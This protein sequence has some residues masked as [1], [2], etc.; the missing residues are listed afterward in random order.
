MD[1]S[2]DDLLEYWEDDVNT[3]VIV[4]YQESFGDPRKFGRIARRVSHK[5]PVIAVKAGRSAVGAKAA[6]SH[7]G[8]L[9]ASDVAVDALFRH[10]GVIRVTTIEEMFNAAEVLTHQPLPKSANEAILTTPEAWCACGH[11]CE[12]GTES[13]RSLDAEEAKVPAQSAPC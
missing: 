13:L 8:A 4:L 7:T 9:A 5:K 12:H 10:S 1:I 11:A 2:T 3:D 6:S